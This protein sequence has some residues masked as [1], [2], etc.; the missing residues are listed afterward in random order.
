MFAPAICKQIHSSCVRAGFRIQ[1][2]LKPRVFAGCVVW[3]QVEQDFQIQLV[4]LIH[5]LSEIGN[6]PKNRI[7][8][9]V[10][11]YV[12]TTVFLR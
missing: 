6:S 3:N 2:V 10:I 7:H 9:V 12:V 4:R 8:T 5:H 11:A 1:R